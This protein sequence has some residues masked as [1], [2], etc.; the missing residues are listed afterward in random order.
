MLTHYGKEVAHVIL[1]S[2]DEAL[3]EPSAQPDR[4]EVYV[5]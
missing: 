5:G 4:T 1:N 3:A 2:I